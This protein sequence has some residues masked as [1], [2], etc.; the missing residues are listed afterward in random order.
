MCSRASRW[1]SSACSAA[2]AWQTP[3]WEWLTASRP[4]WA[5]C[6]DMPHGLACGILLPH[7]I[8]YNRAACTNELAQAL[9][10]FLNQPRASANAIDEGIAVIN[11]LN[12]RLGIPRDLKH[13]QLKEEDLKRLAELPWEAACRAIPC[14]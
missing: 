11:E 7:A 4:D 6:F 14:R 13:L 12:G 10:A 3:D 1:R 9:T 8:R 5:P 2:S